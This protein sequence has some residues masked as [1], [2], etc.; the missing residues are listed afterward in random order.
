MKNLIFLY[1]PFLV[2]KTLCFRRVKK[3]S[4]KKNKILTVLSISFLLISLF[5]FINNNNNVYADTTYNWIQ[6]YSFEAGGGNAFRN[7]GFET[8][9]LTNWD[10]IYNCNV[11]NGTHYNDDGLWCLEG[12][13]S[14]SYMPQFSQTLTQNITVSNINVMYYRY[15]YSSSPSGFDMYIDFYF[16]DGNITRIWTLDNYSTEWEID[17]IDTSV[18]NQTRILYKVL[19]GIT[20]MGIGASVYFDT[21]M[22]DYGSTDGQTDFNEDTLPFYSSQE[23][24]FAGINQVIGYSGSCSAYMGYAHSINGK[25]VQ[26]LPLLSTN[27]ISNY[28]MMILTP[29]EIQIRSYLI[30]SDGTYST[31]TS[32]W[33]DNSESWQIVDFTNDIVPNKQII[34][35]QLCLAQEVNYYINFDEILLL[36]SVPYGQSIFNWNLSPNPI[37]NTSWTFSAYQNLDYTFTGIL[38]Y[39]NGTLSSETGT[40][41]VLTTKGLINGTINDGSF[42]FIISARNNAFGNIIGESILI[43]ING[44]TTDLTVKILAD[45]INT[46]T[47]GNIE[48]DTLPNTNISTTS[49]ISFLLLMIFLLMIPLALALYCGINGINPIAGFLGGITMTGLICYMVGMLPLYGLFVIIVAD[50]VMILFL[51]ERRGA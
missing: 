21:F 14:A 30:Y 1:S 20:S 8:G 9:D 5:V 45:W 13:E 15:I 37:S 7:A 4:M 33:L 22:L 38:Y 48:G 47:D 44:T 16:T 40:F 29:T 36:S 3:Q 11:N 2:K 31:L 17:I 12:E 6:N 24:T 28:S 50:A 42:S 43:T 10:I 18:L 39:E 41:T 25:I 49:F 26:D 27:T 23:W 19:F 32:N 34:Q 51:F 35:I 46:N